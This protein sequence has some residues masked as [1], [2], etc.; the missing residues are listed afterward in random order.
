MKERLK[1]E[2]IKQWLKRVSIVDRTW[3]KK[4]KKR[5]NLHNIIT[6]KNQNK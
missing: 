4:A 2:T 6:K 1:E 3:V 5:K